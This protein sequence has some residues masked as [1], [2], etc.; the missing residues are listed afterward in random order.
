MTMPATANKEICFVETDKEKQSAAATT[1]RSPLARASNAIPIR[2]KPKA[3]VSPKN[4]PKYQ[5]L[6]LAKTS[7]KRT[8]KKKPN[9]GVHPK[10]RQI[11]IAATIN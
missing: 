6:E 5:L 1:A 9:V 7:N 4:E 2:T 10:R 11:T 3:T 8:A